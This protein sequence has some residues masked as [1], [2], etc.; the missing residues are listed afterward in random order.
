MGNY[1]Y[2]SGYNITQLSFKSK[3]FYNFVFHYTEIIPFKQLNIHF[4]KMII[5]GA[6]AVAIGVVVA[7]YIQKALNKT[8]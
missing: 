7:G 6:I 4:M 3:S 5:I 8:A 1:L 2:V